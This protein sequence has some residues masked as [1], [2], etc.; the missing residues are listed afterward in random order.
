METNQLPVMNMDKSETGCCPRFN[1][2]GWE[3]ELIFDNKKFVKAKTRSFFHI[4]L[5]MGSVFKKVS[6]N[7]EKAG[8]FPDDHYLT[9]THDPSAWK[10]EHFFAVTKDVPAE[11]VTTLSGHYLT[12]VFEGSFQHAG[13][14]AME[15]DVYVKNRGQE[16]K[17][18]YF[19]YTTCPRCLKVYGKNYVVAFAEV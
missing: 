11:E 9:L 4:P 8:A 16:I 2:E 13:K 15:M 17:K 19:F 3:T 12:K 1:P 14:W 6:A 5:N 18:L 7:I 10:S